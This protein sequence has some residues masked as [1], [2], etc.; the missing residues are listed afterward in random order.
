MTRMHVME[1]LVCISRLAPKMKSKIP[2]FV[3]IHLLI[4][5]PRGAPEA[6]RKPRGPGGP[7]EA[8]MPQGAPGPSRAPP[9][10]FRLFILGSFGRP[11]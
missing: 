7:R 11:F 4:P 9:G 1:A 6:P 10:T 8:P 5:R 2:K 3:Q